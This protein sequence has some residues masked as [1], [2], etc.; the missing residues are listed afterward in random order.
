L[1][2]RRTPFG[3]P[4]PLNVT[5]EY[6][7]TSGGICRQ[8]SPQGP[9]RRLADF[10]TLLVVLVGFSVVLTA[11]SQAPTAEMPQSKLRLAQAIDLA[12]KNYPQIRASME[13]QVAAQGGIAVAR[14]VYLPRADILWQ[15]NRAT[16][17]NIYGLLLPQGIV[18]S[19]SGPVLTADNTRSAWS[20]AGGMLLSWQPFDFGR[21]NA[22]VNVARQG[23]AVATAG[24]H[25]TRLDVA[26]VTANAY[27]DLVTAEQ[28]FVTAQ[29]NVKRLQVFDNTVHV[30]VDNQLRPGA[31]AALADAS[32]AV[33][34]NQLIQANTSV[35]VR[36]A[37]LAD[38]VG[39][40]TR[41][42]EVE[43]AQLLTAEP[44]EN[45]APASLASHPLLEQESA[46]VNQSQAQLSVLT[47]SYVPQF[48]TLASLSGRGAGTAL[49]GSFPG[50]TNGL[51]PN[52]LNWAAGIQATFPAFDYFSLRAQKKVQEANIRAEQARYQQTLDDLSAQVQQAQAQ[53]AG[54]QQIALNTPVELAAAQAS[55][56]Q[57]RARF[58]AGLATVVDVAVA[59]S[60]LT[61]AEVDDAVARLN[62]WRASA[63][64]AAARGDLTPFLAQ[65]AQQ[66]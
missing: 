25:R 8:H 17:N 43:G 9:T 24:M 19:I 42:L 21:R 16:A 10:V 49:D 45:S 27:F 50:G 44:V 59:E 1:K 14:T 12:E 41:N 60:L 46:V 34:K 36:R 32:L 37:A 26:V 18:P 63:G 33:A 66:P 47:H 6:G 22:E 31:D 58:Q 62:I 29:A 13:Q 28:L 54:A 5:Y 7:Y 65:L 53:L 55:E 35:E 38:L 56:Q 11:Q 3:Q 51:A 20:S 64:V 2:Q 30:L 39:I 48:N 23:A 40:P 4:V 15:T 52:T 57:Q 61:Q